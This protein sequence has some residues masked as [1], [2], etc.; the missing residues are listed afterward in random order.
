MG[1]FTDHRLEVWDAATL[2]Y[3]YHSR[4]MPVDEE[5]RKKGWTGSA[6][7]LQEM[8]DKVP[9]RGTDRL[10]RKLSLDVH[11]L[12]PS[13]VWGKEKREQIVAYARAL[14]GQ[15]G[16]SIGPPEATAQEVGRG[17]FGIVA[18]WFSGGDEHS[19]AKQS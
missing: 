10:A 15:N 12:I 5:D 8:I 13:Y 18:G 7:V 6:G 9:T 3:W 19:K 4:R 2:L 16:L 1:V 11:V 17:W 14:A